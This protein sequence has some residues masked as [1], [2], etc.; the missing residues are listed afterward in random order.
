MIIPDAIDIFLDT[1]AARRDETALSVRGQSVTFGAF[2]SRVRMFAGAFSRRPGRGVLIA[3]PQ[4]PDAY[5]AMLGAGLAGSYY[6]PLNLQ[7][8]LDKL[9]HIAQLMQPEVV[10]ADPELFR[11]LLPAASEVSLL[12]PATLQGPPLAGRGTRHEIGYII[13]TSG[14]TGLPKG[15]VIPKT[16]LNHYLDWIR[17]SRTIVAEDRVVQFPNIAFDVSVTDIYGSLCNGATLYPAISKSDRNFPARMIAREKLTVWN[18]TPSVISLMMQAGE[19]TPAL[20]GSL[21]MVNMCGE[22]LLPTH[23]SALYDALPDLVV[24]NTYGPTE[25]TVS[26][27]ELRLNSTNYR[28]AC[29]S[30]VA[31]GPPIPRMS[32]HLLGGTHADEGEIVITGPQLASGYWQDPEKTAAAFKQIIVDGRPERA[33]F[34]GDWAERHGDHVF[35]K[36]RIDHQV[37]IQGFRLE[38]GEVAHAIRECGF[39]EVCVFMSN[40]Q[41]TAVIEH[42]PEFA[43]N[44]PDLRKA[45]TGK[46]EPHAIPTVIRLIDAIP[47]TANDKLDRDAV[48][49]WLES[50]ETGGGA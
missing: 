40:G 6:A 2:E 37:K 33:Y 26:V 22:P 25:T 10:V 18:S 48:R 44:E 47:R 50:S 46:L 1:A 9:R 35:F 27:T 3:L 4:G 11:S 21:R 45:L 31:I 8:P 24:Q 14:T 49:L 7:A 32:I 42:S 28:A 5:A 15:V 43:F 39:P 41:L 38:L 36:A 29:G 23:L 12:D 30:S 13:F 16:A 19:V 17:E 34:S 20:L